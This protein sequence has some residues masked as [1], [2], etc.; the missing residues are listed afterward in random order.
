MNI[1][2]TG[3]VGFVGKALCPYL[4]DKG[5]NVFGCD[6]LLGNEV[7]DIT[8]EQLIKDKIDCIIHLAAQ[9]SVWNEDLMLIE[10]D[11]I[12]SFIHIFKL[13]KD[14]DLK[15]I[16]ASSSCSINVTSMYG[17][18]KQFD[19]SFIELYKHNKCVGLRFHNV[20]G[21]NSREN[22][23]LGICMKQDSVLL[24]NKGN[25]I[26][27]FTYI[28]DVCKGIENALT[29]PSGLYNICNPEVTTTLD[30]CNE[31]A[32]Y[33]KLWVIPTDELRPLDKSEQLVDNTKPS[34]INNYTTYKDGLKK[35]FNK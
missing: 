18:S 24:Y 30:F 3:S 27:H 13:A 14:L 9:T 26:R 23:L 31:V 35:I 4:I 8:K 34:A 28:E 1:L 33:K 11:N 21:P 2:V 16:Y 19:D 10:N 7:L 5:H 12:K 32:K 29:L 20:Y 6:R 22:T 17:L 15:F 25:N